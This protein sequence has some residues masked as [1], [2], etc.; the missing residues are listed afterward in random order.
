MHFY[1]SRFEVIIARV[2]ASDTKQI[3]EIHYEQKER[4]ER[5]APV[6]MHGVFFMSR[7]RKLI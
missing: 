4:P 7:L 3:V 2:A 5:D 1:D 6:E